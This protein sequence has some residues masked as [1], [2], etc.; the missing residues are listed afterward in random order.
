MKAT[1]N[2]VLMLLFLLASIQLYI[3]RSVALDCCNGQIM[4]DGLY[5]FSGD[6]QERLRVPKE[7]GKTSSEGTSMKMY[8]PPQR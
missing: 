7:G 6:T 4:Y 8:V 1:Y 3:F 5:E 2:L